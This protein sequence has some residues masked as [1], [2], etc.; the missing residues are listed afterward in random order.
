VQLAVTLTL[1]ETTDITVRLSTQSYLTCLTV[2]YPPLLLLMVIVAPVSVCRNICRVYI[3]VLSLVT[4]EEGSRDLEF[5][6]N[7]S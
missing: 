7:G 4:S 2:R 6:Q 3:F 5:L 1:L